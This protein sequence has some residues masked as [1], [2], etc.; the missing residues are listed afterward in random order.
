MST[1]YSPPKFTP[2]LSVPS[3][4]YQPPVPSTTGAKMMSGS[5]IC[6][7][8]SNGLNFAVDSVYIRFFFIMLTA[9]LVGY[10]IQPMPK[11][12]GELFQNDMFKFLILFVFALVNLYPL[13][14]TKIMIAFFFPIIMLFIFNML[15]PKEEKKPVA[16][17]QAKTSKKSSKKSSK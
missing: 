2:G 8:L 13:D 7:Y 16:S 14:F 1:N 12:V 6:D 5:G 11:A 3:A 15:R 10:T 17:V 4:V 9:V